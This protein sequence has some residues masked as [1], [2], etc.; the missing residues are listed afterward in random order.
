MTSFEPR[1]S[2]TAR[3]PSL[4]QAENTTA[5]VADG[6]S[7]QARCPSRAHCPVNTALFSRDGT[8]IVTA[9]NDGTARVFDVLSEQSLAVLR[10][11]T[12]PVNSARFSR[13]GK[14]I[15]T[16]S[17][18]GTARIFAVGKQSLAVLRGHTGPVRTATFSPDGQLIAIASADET[19]HVFATKAATA[20]PSFAD[21][22]PSTALPSAPTERGSPPPAT[23]GRPA[24]STP[25]RVSNAP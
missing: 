17:D 1:S 8:L 24:S 9:S 25:R 16:A 19:G 3:T 11:H 14:L 15:V 2:P 6:E 7:G 10:G 5:H 21:T 20:S 12:G 13:D 23:T 22:P 4:R 18:D